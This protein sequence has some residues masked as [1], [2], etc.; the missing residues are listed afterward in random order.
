MAEHQ[1]GTLSSLDEVETKTEEKSSAVELN[2]VIVGIADEVVA[3]E[4][5]SSVGVRMD[6]L[7]DE[8]VKQPGYDERIIPNLDSE[9]WMSQLEESETFNGERGPGPRLH[10]LQRLAKPFI[11]A[12]HCEVSHLIIVPRQI[13][14]ELKTHN[15]NGDLMSTTEELGQHNF[16]M[17]SVT[18]SV[19]D[20]YGRTFSAAADAYYSNCNDLGH[21]P[22]AVAASRAEAR[23]L[24]KLLGIK[25]H[26]AEELAEGK[27][28]QEELAPDDDQP[29]KGTQIKLI[30]KIM[31]DLTDYSLKELFD[32]ITAREIASVE[33]LTTGEAKQALRLLHNK[34]KKN[35][36][37]AKAK[38]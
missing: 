13:I 27:E 9:D 36:K 31:E 14:K 11:Q 24:R 29:I 32:N 25:Q 16:P 12:E 8:D 35:K 15:S 7:K 33:E 20:I 18:Y 30:N 23:A 38:K 6:T 21:F 5:N 19:T 26:S 17:A 22:T 28:A 4:N 2:E 3:G 10:G 1:S 37:K 34:K